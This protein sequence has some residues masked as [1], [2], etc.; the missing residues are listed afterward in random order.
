MNDKANTPANAELRAT[1]DASDAEKWRALMGC[2]RVRVLGHAG[3]DPKRPLDPYDKPYG[4]FAHIGLELWTQHSAATEPTA[5]GWL[6]AFAT[7]A[8]AIRRAAGEQL[9]QVTEDAIAKSKHVLAAVDDYHDRPTQETRSALRHLL[10]DEF[11]AAAR[12]SALLRAPSSN[13]SQL[14][15][16]LHALRDRCAAMAENTVVAEYGGVEQYGDKAAER[17]RAIKLEVSVE[18]H[19]EMNPAPDNSATERAMAFYA[20]EMDAMR[21]LLDKHAPKTRGLLKRRLEQVLTERVQVATAGPSG[22]PQ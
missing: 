4:D 8:V 2:A 22:S 6:D 12:A 13:A 18:R 16:L 5:L 3:C 1:A 14:T 7:K 17:I 11:T 20:A 9:P 19:L 21:E 10:M 15:E